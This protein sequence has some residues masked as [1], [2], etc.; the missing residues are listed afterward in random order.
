M[1]ISKFISKSVQEWA[2]ALVL[3]SLLGFANVALA[4]GFVSDASDMVKTFRTGIYAVVGVLAGLALLWQFVQGWGGRKTWTDIL[5]TSLW[6][7]GAG[8]AIAFAT[9]L[10][11]KGGAMSF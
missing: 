11:T 10:F 8:A 1:F 7:V 9:W 5:E 4:A 6:I 2:K 3:C